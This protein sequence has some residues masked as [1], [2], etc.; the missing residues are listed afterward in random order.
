M[1]EHILAT[2]EYLFNESQE[3][4]IACET[5][6]VNF[7]PNLPTELRESLPEVTLFML[8]NYSFETASIDA[9]YISFE[10]GFGAENFGALV[11]IPLLAVKQVFVEEYPILI[12]VSSVEED[13]GEKEE[14]V[15]KEAINSMEAL[16]N[17]PENAKLLKRK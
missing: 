17:N 13:N 6:T 8:A 4:G 1:K 15:E 10:A 7:E 16:L 3:F 11:H 9:H 5:S 12:N 14:V 2:I